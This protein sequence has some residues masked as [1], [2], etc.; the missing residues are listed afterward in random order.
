MSPRL[1]SRSVQ[2]VSAGAWECVPVTASLPLAS[3]PWHSAYEKS[4]AS[5]DVCCTW[6]FPGCGER[7]LIFIMVVGFSL[8]GP[9][10]WYSAGSR[11]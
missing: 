10:L 4:G 8:R 3:H 6:T 11:L 2:S 5:Q 9:L 1:T 7:G